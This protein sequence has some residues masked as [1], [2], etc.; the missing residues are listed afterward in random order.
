M[1]YLGKK[2]G[3]INEGK[4]ISL[5]L[6]KSGKA[7]DKFVEIVKHQKGNIKF[8]FNPEKYP[9]SEFSDKILSPE[10]G[11]LSAINN[12]EIGMAALELGAGRRTK[13]DKIDPKAGIIFHAKIGN[14]F[15][16]GDVIAEVFSDNKTKIKIAR[17]KIIDSLSFSEKKIKK[18]KLIK[19]III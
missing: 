19:K 5:E 10:K 7:F 1:I 3:S 17:S 18:Q 16:K 14:Q 9:K 2:A 8:L 6:I 11:Y 12:Y 4:E 15:N 13:E